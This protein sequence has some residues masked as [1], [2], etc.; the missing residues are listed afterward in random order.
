M[1]Q[2]VVRLCRSDDHT[3]TYDLKYQL[4]DN[5]FVPKWISEY[6]RTQVRGD[7]ISTR[8]QF[9]GLNDDW[10]EEK[11]IQIINERVDQINHLVPGLIDRKIRSPK[12][13]D[14]LNYL[15]SF[16]EKYH[17]QIDAWLTDPWWEDKPKEMRPIWSD[18]NNY[19][20][21]M[22]DYRNGHPKPKIKV[23]WYDCPKINKFSNEDYKLFEAGVKFGFM[24]SQ[25]ADV[26]KD[27]K[28]LT[29]DNDE[30]HIDFVPPTFVSADFQLTFW[31]HSQD[32]VERFKKDCSQFYKR[33][34]NFFKSKGFL[35]NDP[36]LVIGS[37]P[38]GKLVSEKAEQIILNELK[39]FNRI[40]GVYLI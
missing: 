33:N 37:I 3:D 1:N 6:Q 23:C 28:S 10:S 4:L 22:E 35:E 9:Y 15:H 14:T 7:D 24:Y 29:Y 27:L 2:V 38:I 31:T 18:L 13:Q 30:H 26:G 32:D 11:I 21:R 16:F 36:R 8:D 34:E 25:Y 17:G 5:H 40:Q 12:D 19:I 20:H 39:K